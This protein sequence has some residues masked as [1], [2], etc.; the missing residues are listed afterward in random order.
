MSYTEDAGLRRAGLPAWLS[1]PVAA[2]LP[3][4]DVLVRREGPA[5]ASVTCSW[6]EGPPATLVP[7]VVEVEAT[8]VPWVVEVETA[9]FSFSSAAS[10]FFLA[11]LSEPKLVLNMEDNF[12]S[13]MTKGLLLRE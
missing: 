4:V 13:A 7:W 9:F 6:E 12:L 10:C 5:T 1:S 8:S 2:S 11:S 3:L